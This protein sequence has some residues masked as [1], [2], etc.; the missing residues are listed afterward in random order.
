VLAYL[1]EPCFQPKYF[2]CF[3]PQ[4]STNCPLKSLFVAFYS[5]CFCLDTSPKWRFEVR[6]RTRKM[7]LIISF[8][9]TLSKLL[10]TFFDIYIYIYIYI[11]M[12]I[13][14]YIYIPLT[15]LFFHF[16]PDIIIKKY[17]VSM[18]QIWLL[19]FQFLIDPTNVFFVLALNHYPPLL[20]CVSF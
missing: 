16:S 10:S 13:Y 4:L 3:I 9:H 20:M 5:T 11:Y 2:I 17:V 18:H 12:Y 14:I 6:F 19:K 15:M 1:L 7:S 8:R